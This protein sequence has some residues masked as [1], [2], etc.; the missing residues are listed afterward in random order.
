M[1]DFSRYII[2]T[3]MDGTFLNTD[4]NFVPR[5]MEA[6]ERF[7]AGGGLFTFS[8]GRVHLNLRNAVGDPAEIINAPCVMSN[9]AY[10]YDF[11]EKRAMEESIMAEQDVKELV[12]VIRAKYAD[13]RFRASTVDALRVERTDGLLAK[14]LARYDAG[15]VQISPIEC[16][17]TNDW[18]KIVFRAEADEIGRMRA[19]LTAHFGDRFSYTASGARFLEVQAPGVNK[20]TGLQKLRRICGGDRVLIACGDYEN[21]MEMLTAADV[22]LCPANAMDAVKGICKRTLCHCNDGLIGAIVALLEKGEF[23]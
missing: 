10:L 8:T 3:D 19:E 1:T 21:D 2:A 17:P 13:A 5:N 23:E 9:G 18:Y 6:V 7:K 11:T 20:A 16:W 4:G 22:A 15:A 14:D 12:A